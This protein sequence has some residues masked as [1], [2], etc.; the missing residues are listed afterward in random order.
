MIDPR[1]GFDKQ[2]QTELLVDAFNLP[3]VGTGIF[4]A[5]SGDAMCAAIFIAPRRKMETSAALISWKRARDLATA[6]S[7]AIARLFAAAIS[8]LRKTPAGERGS[9]RRENVGRE[10]G[11]RA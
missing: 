5:T 9:A 7:S 11:R 4:E 8:S 1:T 3:V 2:F 6:A 10:T